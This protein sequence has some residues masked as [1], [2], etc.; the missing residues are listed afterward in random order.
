MPLT[1]EQ[2]LFLGQHLGVELPPDFVENKKRAVEYKKRSS[3]FLTQLG[4]INKRHDAAKLTPLLEQA[5]ASADNK[6]FRAALDLLDQL[7][8]GLKAP[9][10]PPP[11]TE[12]PPPPPKAGDV[13]PSDAA[14]DKPSE[15]EEQQ[16]ARTKYEALK[17]TLAKLI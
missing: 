16:K 1:A 17:P 7:E 4:E 12:P 14:G 6:D 10:L 2:A 5:A 11:P 3:E 8:T 13:A 15:A 9:D